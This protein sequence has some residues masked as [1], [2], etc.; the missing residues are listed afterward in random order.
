MG[1][2]NGDENIDLVV[3]NFSDDDISVLFGDGGGGFGGRQDYPVGNYPFGIVAGDFNEDGNPDLAVTNAYDDD[4]SVLFGDSGGGFGNRQDY[5][6][7]S[8]WGIVTADFNGDDNLDLAVRA[9]SYPNVGIS[10]LLGDGIGGFGDRQD[11][12]LPGNS[13]GSGDLVTADFN[14][15]GNLDLA[16]ENWYNYTIS[17]LLGDGNGGFGSQQ[18]YLV[19]DC[20]P[21]GTVV[22]D[23]NEDGNLDLGRDQREGR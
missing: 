18:D 22:G 7:E 9:G 8:C 4:I 23:F 12:L 21:S 5:P 11:Y 1:D 14:G 13:G 15:D 20:C 6:L 16:G 19:G 10:I 2:F 17:V 3:A